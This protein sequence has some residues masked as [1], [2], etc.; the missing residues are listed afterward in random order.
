MGEYGTLLAEV[1][2]FPGPPSVAA[3]HQ[4]RTYKRSYLH[5][6]T[7]HTQVAGHNARQ[8]HLQV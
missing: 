2:R 6:Q 3:V 4:P 1:A 8:A 5:V 7:A